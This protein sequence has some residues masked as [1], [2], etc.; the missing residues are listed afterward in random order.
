MQRDAD[1]AA[2]PAVQEK[3]KKEKQLRLSYKEKV[4]L[5]SLP[6][7]IEALEAKMEQVNTCLAD[8]NCY[9]DKGISVLARELEALEAEYEAKIEELLTIEEKV[10]QI[11]SES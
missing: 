3:P 4:A 11:G 7:E 10:E 1:A 8:P 5:E 2:K 9:G 6:G